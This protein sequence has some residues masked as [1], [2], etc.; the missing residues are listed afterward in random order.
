PARGLAAPSQGLCFFRGATPRAP[1]CALACARALVVWLGGL[2][3]S[4]DSVRLAGP[5]FFSGGRPPR[6]PR[7]A[8]ACARALVVWLGGLGPPSQGLC[9]FRGATPVPPPVRARWCSCTW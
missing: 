2:Q 1:R 8:L 5:S 4:A 7:C 6:A 9:S 3:R